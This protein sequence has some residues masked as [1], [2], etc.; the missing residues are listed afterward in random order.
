MCLEMIAQ[1]IAFDPGDAGTV[2][3]ESEGA[4]RSISLAMLVVQGVSVAPGD[5]LL[6]HTGIALEKLDE[7]D[8]LAR[9]AS[10]NAAL[11]NLREDSE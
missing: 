1:V 3:A 9:I 8:A 2:I 5:W 7:S 11:L 6:A 10:R 4:R